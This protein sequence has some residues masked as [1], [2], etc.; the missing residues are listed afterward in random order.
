MDVLSAVIF[1][2]IIITTI[3]EKGFTKVSQR[4]KMTVMAGLIAAFVCW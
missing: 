1:A 3:T 2:G 4:V